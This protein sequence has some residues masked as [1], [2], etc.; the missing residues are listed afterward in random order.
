[1]NDAEQFERADNMQR[2]GTLETAKGLWAV[3]L[4]SDGVNPRPPRG[5][6]HIVETVPD[7]EGGLLFLVEKFLDTGDR[8]C[9]L[10]LPPKHMMDCLLYRTPGEAIEAE[11]YAKEDAAEFEAELAAYQAEKELERAAAGILADRRGS[12]LAAMALNRESPRP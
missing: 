9:M 12:T 2:Q 7:G 5:I 4:D 1:M 11:K 8:D 6:G 10:F 3:F